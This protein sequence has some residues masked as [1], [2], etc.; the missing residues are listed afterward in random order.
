MKHSLQ[1]N[2]AI[3]FNLWI[4]LFLANVG[5][6][7]VPVWFNVAVS[8]RRLGYYI[9]IVAGLLAVL[10][11]IM[12]IGEENSVVEYE[13]PIKMVDHFY[14]LIKEHRCEEA[15]QLRPGYTKEQ[16][17]QVTEVIDYKTTPRFNPAGGSVVVIELE[18]KISKAEK[19]ESWHGFITVIQRNNLWKIVNDSYLSQKTTGAL[20]AYLASPKYQQAVHQAS[21]L[22]SVVPTSPPEQTTVSL[23]ESLAKSIGRDSG[24]VP[25]GTTPKPPSAILARDTSEPAGALDATLQS[26]APPA[27]PHPSQRQDPHYAAN[28]RNGATTILDACWSPEALRGLPGERTIRA[29]PANYTPPQRVNPLSSNAPLGSEFARSVRSVDP[30][31]GEKL[32]ALTFDLCEQA[33]EVTGYDGELVDTLRAEKVNATFYAGGKWMRS[34][35]ERTMQIMADPLFEIGN[36]AWTHGN[37]RVLR[38]KEMEEQIRWTQAQYELLREQLL[39]LPCATSVAKSQAQSISP[40][41]STFRFPYGTCDATAL[42]AVAQAGL[43]PIQWNI[44]SGDPVR[45]QNADQMAKE[46]LDKVRPGSIVIAH[47]NGRGWHTSEAL[48]TLIPALKKRGYRFVTVS[49]LIKSGNPVAVEF[50]YE[51]RPGDNLKYDKLFGRGTE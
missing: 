43:Y 33:N 31:H 50:C 38:D 16:C 24:S 22:A 8:Q 46:I 51:L 7:I 10:F 27:P 26:I 15:V 17:Q 30:D 23:N 34:H 13:S 9:A 40:L 21:G 25:E 1:K 44:V 48:K 5:Y 28:P 39:N 2:M 4:V 20:P 47:A 11:P 35:P 37:L 49:Q 45:R 6:L 12:G 41:P 42:K 29:Y 19:Q 3:L 36:H 18:V 32:V 14:Q